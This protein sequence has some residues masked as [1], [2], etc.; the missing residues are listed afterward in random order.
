MD[1]DWHD[2]S[3]W[4]FY[5]SSKTKEDKKVA[6][7]KK[8]TASSP[9]PISTICCELD[10]NHTTSETGIWI[11]FP[12][13]R[14]AEISWCSFWWDSFLPSAAQPSPHSPAWFEEQQPPMPVAPP[15]R[16]LAMRIACTGQQWISSFLHM[17]QSHD[18][19]LSELNWVFHICN[20]RV[21]AFFIRHSSW[22]VYF[23]WIDS[24]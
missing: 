4:T 10:C 1:W 7:F 19:D 8:C 12:I 16:C 23:L 3:D 17:A 20:A 18:W 6:L 9:F 11:C 2:I 14:E 15:V 22:Q 5:G 13:V 24:L 21:K